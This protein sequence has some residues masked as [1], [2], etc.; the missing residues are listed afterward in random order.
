MRRAMD[1][2]ATAWAH[3]CS[4]EGHDP[5][6]AETIWR[7]AASC[8]Q[9]RLRQLLCSR[10][11]TRRGGKSEGHQAHRVDDFAEGPEY[12]CLSTWARA[13][14]ARAKA[15][16]L[17]SEFFHRRQQRLPPTTAPGRV[18]EEWYVAA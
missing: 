5:T 7:G 3:C 8:S 17:Q 14:A 18:G 15:L 9:A 16:R 13:V 6:R 2:P 1:G 12:G 10:G 4:R 11:A